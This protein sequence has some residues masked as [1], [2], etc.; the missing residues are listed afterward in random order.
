[1]PTGLANIRR[2]KTIKEDLS[3]MTSNV[4]KEFCSGCKKFYNMNDGVWTPC[5]F[6]DGVGHTLAGDDREKI[7]INSDNHYVPLRDR[8]DLKRR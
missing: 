6:C 8:W 3:S 2:Q 1:M 4:S 7:L 5:P